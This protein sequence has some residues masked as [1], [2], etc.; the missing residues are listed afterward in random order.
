MGGPASYGTYGEL[1]IMRNQTDAAEDR[2]SGVIPKAPWRVT[3]V[4]ALP[5]YQL[6]VR[7]QDGSEGVVDLSRLIHSD[8]AGVFA[9]L[10]NMT[11]FAQ[12]YLELGVVTW[13]GGIDLAPDA[14]HREIN[15]H[16]KWVL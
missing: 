10:C 4:V 12:V 6:Q 2:A 16:G 13:P 9:S 15:Q 11:V 7:F 3:E 1:E 14:M 5:G 8:E